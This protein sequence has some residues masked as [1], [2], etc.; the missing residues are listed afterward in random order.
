M[1]H[2]SGN[3]NIQKS[4][5]SDDLFQ[6]KRP[7]IPPTVSAFQEAP[8]TQRVSKDQQQTLFT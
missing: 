4:K 3:M 2:Q 8:L 7:E 6:G 5:F 1:Y